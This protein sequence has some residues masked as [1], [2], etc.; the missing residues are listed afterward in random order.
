MTDRAGRVGRGAVEELDVAVSAEDERAVQLLEARRFMK[1]ALAGELGFW[2]LLFGTGP[3]SKLAPLAIVGYVAAWLACVL[4]VS[5]GARAVG[6]HPALRIVFYVLAFG[7]LVRLVPIAYFLGRSK[8]AVGPSPETQKQQAM[9]EAA[10]QRAKERER[11]RAAP[12]AEP[13]PKKAEAANPQPRELEPLEF[14]GTSALKPAADTPAKRPV[15]QRALERISKAV[16]RIRVLEELGL[17]DGAPMQMRFAQPPGAPAMDLE[18]ISMPVM[19][20]T[21]GLFGVN[22]MVDEGSQY[23]SVARSEMEAAGLTLDGLHQLAM[24]NLRARVATGQPGLKL[25]RL[26]Q[27]IMLTLDGDNEASLV[28][29]DELWDKAFRKHVPNGVMAVIPAR[30]VCVFIDMAAVT[31]G[32]LGELQ[33]AIAA[34]HQRNGSACNAILHRQNGAWVI[35]ARVTGL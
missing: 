14:V 33:D 17:P 25:R 26:K 13:V 27:A 23:L 29:L 34:I 7:L 3:Q 2:V 35:G 30:D 15:D 1:V 20:A 31:Q 32:G 22:Y 19:R 9:V 5:R 12:P 21:R 11:A 18:D 8:E 6:M 4:G 24:K 10:R 28:L 16:P